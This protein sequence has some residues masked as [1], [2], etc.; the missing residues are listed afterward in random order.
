MAVRPWQNRPE[1]RREAVRRWRIILAAVFFSGALL[2]GIGAGLTMV[3]WSSLEYVGQ[4][5]LGREHLVT[6]DFDFRIKDDGSKIVLGAGYYTDCYVKKVEED[7]AVP[8]GIVRYRVTYNDALVMPHVEYTEYDREEEESAPSGQ[9][10]MEFGQQDDGSEENFSE[11]ADAE[12]VLDGVIRLTRYFYGDEWPL[13]MENKDEILQDLK[14]GKISSYEI[15]E[16]TDVEVLINPA[17]MPRV[18]NQIERIP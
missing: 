15:A 17:T 10:E 2:G 18:E 5:L 3:E 12:P 8:E 1:R 9:Q 4:K 13:L 7:P 11:P 16:I 14:Q 6:E